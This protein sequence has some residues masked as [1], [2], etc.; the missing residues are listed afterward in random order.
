[1]E[2]RLQKQRFER[3]YFITERQATDIREMIRGHMVPDAFSRDRSH[4]MYP[5]YSLYVDSDDLT[6]Y[7]ATVHCEARRF[8]LRV[9]YYSDDPGDPLFFEI[10]R[11][12]N[13]CILKHRGAVHRS[14]GAALL[15]GEWPC[16]EHLHFD[17]AS[18]L[19]A[20]QRF[21]RLMLRLNARPTIAVSYMREAW[22]SPY[23]NSA[24]LTIDRDVMGEPRREPIFGI[25]M[26]EAVRPFGDRRVLE[27]KFTDRFP[28]WFRDLAQQ[29]ELHQSAAPK[30]CGS[31]ALA[32][33]DVG[34]GPG[35]MNAPNELAEEVMP[36]GWD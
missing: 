35:R 15:S 17:K 30:Y 8:K 1:M 2:D 20:L 7:W 14:A 11:R 29:F 25:E 32:G 5:V 12:E 18:H 10:K 6:T 4:Y 9:R 36:W 28:D 21:C 31:V 26:R 27:L 22:M 19:V 23:G 34:H 3:K 13:D 16:P 33:R 24:R